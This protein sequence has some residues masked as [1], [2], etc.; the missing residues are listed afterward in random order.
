MSYEVEQKHPVS[1]PQAVLARLDE[2]G[3][4]WQGAVLQVDRYYRHP[5]RD[6][7]QTD[8]ALRIRRVGDAN[9]ITYKGP[10]LDRVT[11]T[12]REIEL[13][14]A[15]GDQGDHAWHEL[16]TAL[17]FTPV[18]EVRKRRRPGQ[19]AWR[20]C[21]VTLAWDEVEQVGTYLELE[22]CTEHQGLD[23]ARALVRGLAAE[24]QLEAGERRSYLEML[25]SRTGAGTAGAPLE[26]GAS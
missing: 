16:L 21:P 18:A 7:A 8:E 20:D 3:V 11:K 1:E 12:R 24:L 5:A 9:Y 25:L 6:F 15:A 19:L 23:A 2:R 17:G 13:A 14:L 4:S 10:K 26:S 22:V